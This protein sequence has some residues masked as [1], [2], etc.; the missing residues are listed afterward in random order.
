MH[1]GDAEADRLAKQLEEA[2]FIGDTTVAIDGGQVR[3]VR[4]AENTSVHV[5]MQGH[6]H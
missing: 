5:D 1:P 3:I 4:S 6:E 2:G